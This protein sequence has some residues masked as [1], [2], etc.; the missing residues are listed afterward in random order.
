MNEFT[1]GLLLLG[2]AAVLFILADVYNIKHF[3]EVF[4][5]FE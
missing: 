1:K 2:L 3:S 5:M 4:K